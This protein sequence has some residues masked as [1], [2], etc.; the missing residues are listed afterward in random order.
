MNDTL[1]VNVD[2]GAVYR[3][4]VTSNSALKDMSFKFRRMKAHQITLQWA[5][6]RGAAEEQA[7]LEAESHRHK[8]AGSQLP[9]LT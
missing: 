8:R 3:E 5:V 7:A 1:S 4:V 2:D 9:L 6:Q